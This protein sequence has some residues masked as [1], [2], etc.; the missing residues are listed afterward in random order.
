[1]KKLLS[2]LLTACLLLGLAACG[3]AAPDPNAGLYEAD[4]VEALGM[5]LQAADVYE[6]GLSIELKNGGKAVFR[7]EGKDYSMKWTLDGQ[8]FTAKGG[9]A[10]LK[11][12][13][14]NGVLRIENLLDSGVN[15]TFVREGANPG[16]ADEAETGMPDPE[17]LPPVTVA[18]SDDFDWWRGTWYGWRV[19]YQVGSAFGGS[20]DS[21]YDVLA[22]IEGDENNATLTIWDYD[23]SA[24]DAILFAPVSLQEGASEHGSL[25]AEGGWLWDMTIPYGAWSID[26]ALSEVS[27]L[28]HMICLDCEYV[29][30]ENEND[31]VRYRFYLRP[32]GMDWEDVRTADTSD[33]SYD[34]MMP[35]FYDDWYLP[36]IGP[37]AVGAAAS[38][39]AGDPSVLFGEWAHGSYRY[40]FN[41]DGTGSYLGGPDPINFSYAVSGDQVTLTYENVTTPNTFTFSVEGDV[42]YITDSFDRVVDY[43]RS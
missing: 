16:A 12:T 10:E 9:G 3:S 19:N 38:A 31:W 28:D 14:A 40:V 1:M 2:L 25:L 41:A 20:E 33:M 34:D 17:A 35:L 22:A 26:P 21:A 39:G 4:T 23:E 36:Q 11:G 13:L 5:T 42:L 30:P 24:E 27:A 18:E 6:N 43:T 15:I 32:W 37:G 7:Y 29:N 8:S